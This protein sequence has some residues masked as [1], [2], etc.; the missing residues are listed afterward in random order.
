M[1]GAYEQ[2]AGLALGLCK[3]LLT[4]VYPVSKSARAHTRTHAGDVAKP[5]ECLLIMYESWFDSPR[6]A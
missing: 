2:Y 1:D 4:Y 6:I 5:L 3:Y